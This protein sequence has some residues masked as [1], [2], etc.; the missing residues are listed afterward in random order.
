MSEA[1]NIQ[2]VVHALQ[3]VPEKRLLLIELANRVGRKGGELDYDEL[4]KVQ[5]EVNLAI[6]E[7]KMYGAHTLLAVD[8]LR[9]LKAR[10]DDV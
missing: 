8:T 6:V 1:E 2:R 7:A 4:A 10:T 5:P 3:K 9:R